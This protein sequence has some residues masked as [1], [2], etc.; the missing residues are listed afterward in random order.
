MIHTS[1]NGAMIC[2][3]QAGHGSEPLRNNLGYHVGDDP[4]RVTQ[5]RAAVSSQ[6]NSPIVWMNQTHSTVVRVLTPATSDYP[7]GLCHLDDGTTFDPSF[8]HPENHLEADGLVIDARQS[9]LPAPGIAVMTADCLPVLFADPTGRVVA[10]VHAGRVGLEN[11]ILLRALE[12]YEELG[13]PSHDLAVLIAPA[14]CGECYEV[15][16]EM[17]ERSENLLPGVRTRTRWG[18]CGLDLPAAA[19]AQLH[20]HG[21]ASISA[22]GQ[23]TMENSMFHSYRRNPLAGR[24]A[25]IIIP[26]RMASRLST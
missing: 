22:L 11:G 15:P 5:Q 10:A 2:C 14:I 23:C 21:V 7:D 8:I 20:A 16:E 18:S 4:L 25:S 17:A 9:S 13:I 26:R 1:L 19:T 12:C 6:C 24:Q 3:T